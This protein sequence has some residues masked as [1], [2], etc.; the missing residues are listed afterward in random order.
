MTILKIAASDTVRACFNTTREIIALENT[1]F[2]DVA[3]AVPSLDDLNAGA[4]DAI[5]STGVDIPIFLV[6]NQGPGKRSLMVGPSS[7]L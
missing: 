2:T 7:T 1:S 5:K 6:V 3:V 4:L